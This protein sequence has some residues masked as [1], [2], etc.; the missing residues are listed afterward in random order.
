MGEVSFV[1]NRAFLLSAEP[2]PI[3]MG[4]GRWWLLPV[5]NVRAQV[6]SSR[7]NS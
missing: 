1:I 2:V 4:R 6:S 7:K 5:K 3:V